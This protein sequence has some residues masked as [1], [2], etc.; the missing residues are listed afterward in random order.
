M[1][2]ESTELFTVKT[3]AAMF[4]VSPATV[5]RLVESGELPALRIGRGKGAVRITDVAISTYRAK[6]ATN[7]PV[8]AT[9]W[10]NLSP[11]QADGLACVRCG[12]EFLAGGE[13]QWPVGRSVTGS[14]VFACASHATTD[15]A[16]AAVVV[17]GEVA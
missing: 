14:Q 6:A 8:P 2:V 13:A 11:A 9:V 12:C 4:R 5:Y 1:Q 17:S 15:Q 10:A 16:V 7:R 3:V